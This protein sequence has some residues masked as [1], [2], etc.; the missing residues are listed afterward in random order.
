MRYG[1]KLHAM[2]RKLA[3]QEERNTMEW[4]L[5]EVGDI[6]C[7]MDDSGLYVVINRV[8]G[9]AMEPTNRD[10][11][12]VRADLMASDNEPIMSWIGSANNI[13]KHMI[14]YIRENYGYAVISS[15][16]ASYIGYELLR[17]ETDPQYVQD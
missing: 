3:L 4:E 10:I 12:R 6:D 9:S 1:R 8:V 17:A 2:S 14:Q 15:E 5:K 11:I 13:R 16:H 7:T